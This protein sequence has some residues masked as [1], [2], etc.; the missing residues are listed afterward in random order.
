MSKTKLAAIYNVWDGDEL[1]EYSINSVKSGVDLFIIVYQTTSNFG[2]KYDP[3]QNILKA[4]KD[5]PYILH[6]FTPINHAGISN[7]REKRNIGLQI[8]KKNSCSHFLHMDCDEMYQDFNKAKKLYFNSGKEGSCC[9]IFTYFKLPTLRFETED[10]YFVPFIHK[11]FDDTRSG[12]PNYP[13][14]VDPTRR[15]NCNNVELL[16]VHMHHFSYIRKDIMRKINNSSAR[17]NFKKGTI[18]QDYNNPDLKC[19]YYVKD[20][21]KKL[22]EVPNLFD[23]FV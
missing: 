15:I 14:Y 10:G 16:N 23:I 17:N 11:L 2:E 4:V 6:K 20:Y 21:E 8:A 7:E 19:G 1:L 13:F 3:L 18:L 22:I 9:K 12:L 5:V